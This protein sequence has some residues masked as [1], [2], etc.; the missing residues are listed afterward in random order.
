MTTHRDFSD[1]APLERI[2][3]AAVSP[4]GTKVAYANG[5]EANYNLFV[6]DSTT[7]TETQLTE[8][9]DWSV[10][11]VAWNNAA[12]A[13][14]FM[15]DHNGDEYHQLFSVA[16]DGSDLTQLTNRPTVVH[17][18]IPGVFSPDDTHFVFSANITDNTTSQLWLYDV[19][20][21][22]ERELTSE[23]G[24]LIPHAWSQDGSQ[25]VGASRVEL[26][27][28][29]A[30]VVDAN[31]GSTKWLSTTAHAEEAMGLT[32]TG[33]I[34]ALSNLDREHTGLGFFAEGSDQVQWLRTPEWTI[35]RAAVSAN[36]A[37]TAYVV[38]ADGY[39]E[40]HAL[41]N[42]TG[43]DV[44]LPQIPVG[45]IQELSISHDGN[46]I[47][48]LL[49]GPQSPPN[50]LL[51]DRTTQECI[52][53]TENRPAG[54]AEQSLRPVELVATT[55]HD[56][57]RLPAFVYKPKGAG[58]FP[59]V[60]SIHGGP[61]TQEVPKYQP[62]YQSLV[63]R[64]I[65]VVAPNIRGSLGY[66]T[67]YSRLI[68]GDWGAGDLQDVATLRDFIAGQEWAD[69]DRMAVWGGSY[70]GFMV[71]SC[72]SRQ[73]DL[74]ACGVDIF[75]PSDL[76]AM[77]E[78]APDT[79]RAGLNT[80]VGNPET[81]RE[82]MIAVSP[83]THADQICKPL[84]VVHGAKDQR[85]TK[86]QSDRMVAKARAA[87]AT[88]RYDVYPD[89]GHGFTRRENENRVMQDSLDFLTEHLQ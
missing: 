2:Q 85:I 38:N 53:V 24:V 9:T 79:W 37:V 16:A 20:C 48:V 71:L 40:L 72:L 35:E 83:I 45:I 4:C 34:M 31:S 3:L 70:G 68:E 87:G 62:L 23:P 80:W 28:L 47:A 10:R 18:V 30:C 15:A 41:D 75:G 84:F 73:P 88:V 66:G 21:G 5:A 81:D 60:F 19:A 33:R 50:V 12:T 7:L 32:P 59:V 65:A 36:G 86:P 56:G 52:Q 6:F 1:F 8:F 17:Y 13:L 69:A 67:S 29:R 89:E 58:P 22:T 42:V 11:S 44:E 78:D 76:I 39:S 61:Q 82:R 49:T 54:A 57:L 26:T 27:K 51:I 74:W 64:G 25:I 63:A 14:V 46:V 77:H 43:D 55:S